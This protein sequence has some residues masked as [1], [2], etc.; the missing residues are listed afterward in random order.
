MQPTESGK[1]AALWMTP[2]LFLQLCT[3]NKTVGLIAKSSQSGDPYPIYACKQRSLLD[4]WF[5]TG[6]ASGS[7]MMVGPKARL[8]EIMTSCDPN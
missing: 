7:I 1:A 5:S 4:Q 8:V 3:E 2:L 6:L